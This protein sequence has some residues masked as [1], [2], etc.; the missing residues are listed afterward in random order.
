M[1]NCKFHATLSKHAGKTEW[2]AFVAK[3]D[4][5]S[6]F[7]VYYFMAGACPRFP[8]RC[9][10][11][12][13]WVCPCCA[14]VTCSSWLHHCF[15]DQMSKFLTLEGG[16]KSKTQNSLPSNMH[17]QSMNHMFMKKGRPKRHPLCR[18]VFANTMLASLAVLGWHA[19][20]LTTDKYWQFVSC[21]FIVFCLQ[22][23]CLDFLKWTTQ[24][25]KV[26]QH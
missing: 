24:E 6:D 20:E 23:W 1:C 15:P 13:H 26:N 11:R 25:M 8:T 17:Q 12:T 22:V 10:L 7:R 14:H 3:N 5:R 18:H 16:Y 21:R 4:L 2:M 19:Q 9:L